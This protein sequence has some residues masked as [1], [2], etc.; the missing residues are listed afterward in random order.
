MSADVFRDLVAGE[1]AVH[2]A[3]VPD[4]ARRSLVQRISY[5]QADVRN[6]DAL[7]PVEVTEPML[8]YFAIPPETVPPAFRAVCRAGIPHAQTRIVFDKPFGLGRTSARALN[9]QVLASLD[10]RN[11]YRVDHFLY[12]HTV[13]ELVRWRVQADALSPVELLPVSEVEIVWD[14]TRASQSGRASYCGVMRDMVQSHL[15]QLAA[16]IT[17]ESPGSMTRDELASHR[18]EALRRISVVMNR[19]SSPVRARHTGSEADSVPERA[20]ETFVTLELRS[21]MPR[22]KHV[23]FLVRAAKGVNESRRHIELRFGH[24]SPPAPIGFIRLEVLAGTLAIGADG[25]GESHVEFAISPDKESASTR[26][27]RAALKGDDT[28]TLDPEE[29]EEAW[30]V[31]EPILRAWEDGDVLTSTY[32]VGAP[33]SEIDRRDAGPGVA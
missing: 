3:H 30:R 27:L 23:R 15:L 24:R 28:F 5:L 31:V 33:A 8:V 4:D 18:L 7:L 26:L 32:R 11:V 1:L 13:Q 22:W 25:D 2:A 6:V 9:E 20:P 19:D 17:M 10:E 12:H 16:A 14:E 21:E 29:P